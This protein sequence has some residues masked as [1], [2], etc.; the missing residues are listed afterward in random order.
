V[1]RLVSYVTLN[2]TATKSIEVLCEEDE[3]KEGRHTWIDIDVIQIC[4]WQIDW[5]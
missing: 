2:G 3:W 1:D 5:N 4:W